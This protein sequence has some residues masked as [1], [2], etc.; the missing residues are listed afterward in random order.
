MRAALAQLAPH[1]RAD[2]VARLDLRVDVEVGDGGP[3]EDP[4]ARTVNRLLLSAIVSSTVNP[5]LS[6]RSQNAKQ[7]PQL[8]SD[9]TLKISGLFKTQLYYFL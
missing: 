3:L 9:Y 4:G 8:T 2:Q 5:I 7:K 6:N 1:G